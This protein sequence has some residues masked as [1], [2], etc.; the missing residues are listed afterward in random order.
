MSMPL[1]RRPKRMHVDSFFQD[2]TISVSVELV[3]QRQ[4][5]SV[6]DLCPLQRWSETVK[7][8]THLNKVEHLKEPYMALIDKLRL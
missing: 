7:D 4:E 6:H 5:V 1:L 8:I 2:E 3:Q